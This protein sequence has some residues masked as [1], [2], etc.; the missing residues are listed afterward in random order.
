MIF[1]ILLFI[2]GISLFIA[3]KKKR[4]LFLLVPFLSIFIYFVIEIILF[5]APIGE[6]IRFIFNLG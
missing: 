5:P 4:P 2:T 6:T 3:F 1:Y